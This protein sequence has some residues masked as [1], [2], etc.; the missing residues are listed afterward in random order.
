MTQIE[1]KG[2]FLCEDPGSYYV[3]VFNKIAA[4]DTIF[5]H[6]E[7]VGRYLESKSISHLLAFCLIV[8]MKER[9]AY[10]RSPLSA[11]DVKMLPDAR[12]EFLNLAKDDPYDK[13]Y[14]EEFLTICFGKAPQGAGQKVFHRIA[15]IASQ[16][17]K[18]AATLLDITL[19]RGA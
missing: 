19:A 7:D 14:L 11:N 9:R 15:E 6:N 10:D 16:V 2:D 3:R 1:K 17:R 5:V 12:N 4:S 8:I 13:M 18:N